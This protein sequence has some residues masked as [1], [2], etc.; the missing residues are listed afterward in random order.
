MCEHL[1]KNGIQKFVENR[2]FTGNG[3]FEL[4]GEG[5]GVGMGS[6]GVGGSDKLP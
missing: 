5:V 6:S 2:N 1:E 4:K 3:H